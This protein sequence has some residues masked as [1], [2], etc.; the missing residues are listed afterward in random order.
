MLICNKKL[1]KLILKNIFLLLLIFLLFFVFFSIVRVAKANIIDDL[2]EKISNTL[3]RREVLDAEIKQTQQKIDEAAGKKQT[4]LKD[5][6][7]L[8]SARNKLDSGIKK[9]ESGISQTVQTIGDIEKDIDLKSQ[10]IELGKGSLRELI[11]DMNLSSG[12]STIEKLLGGEKLSDYLETNQN[13]EGKLNSNILELKSLRDE[14]EQ[15]KSEAE[16]KKRVLSSLKSDL[17]GQK[18]AVVK[19]QATKDILL[20]DTKNQEATYIKLKA[21]KIRLKEQFEKELFQYESELAIAI[22]PSKLPTAAKGVLSWP[23]DNVRITQLF[24]VTSASKRLYVSGTHNGIDFG[25]PD[26][27][28]VKAVLSGTVIGTGDTDLVRGCL[29]YG[30]W[31]AIRHNNGLTSV[32]GHMSGVSASSGQEVTTGQ[33]IG[34]SG[35]SGYA[36]GPHLHL[37]ILASEAVKIGVIPNEKTINCRGITIPLALGTNAFLDPMI[38]LPK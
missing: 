23:L 25:V 1:K 22:D 2:K 28:P 37:S 11:Y 18:Q 29:S 27:S 33:T 16:G 35:R 15:K 21:E 38:Y 6:A 9:T 36:T 10:K 7:D 5:L 3:Q 8:T 17:S 34:W 30:K 4:L 26:G 31:V 20:K 32:Y 19:T 14:L 24:G 12:V 13:L